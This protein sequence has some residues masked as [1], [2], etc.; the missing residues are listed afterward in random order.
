MKALRE[1]PAPNRF[2]PAGYFTRSTTVPVLALVCVMLAVIIGCGRDDTG[3]S[4]LNSSAA[5]SDTKIAYVTNG[6]AQFWVI[7]EKGVANA[8]EELGVQT[9]TVMPTEGATSQQRI[10]EDLVSRGFDGIAVSPIDPENQTGLIN[11]IAGYSKVITH[12]SDAPNSDRL[13]YIGVDNYTAGRMCGDL[14]RRAIPDG[15]KVAIFIGRTEQD[16]AK[17]RRQG[18]IDAILGRD[19]DPNR[20]DPP[21]TTLK[22]NGYE[23]VG[24]YTDQ[25]DRSAAKNNA[26]DVLSRH[27]DIA[28]MVGLFAYNPPLILEALRG[29][30]KLGDVKVIAFDE[31]DATLQGIIDGHVFGTIVQNPY[32]YGYESVRVLN[33]LINGETLDQLGFENGNVLHI[34]PREITAENVEPFWEELKKNVGDP[35]AETGADS[36]T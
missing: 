11:E 10:L 1:H 14:V 2:N 19:P 35:S 8:G 36:A 4:A 22:E 29:A 26:E 9:E 15:G 23:I 13:A 3:S 21:S 5:S 7:A 6:V 34:P 27:G 25:F 33:G 31:D 20:F 17:R 18:T 12:D 28:A 16:N 30:D 32:Q 24:T